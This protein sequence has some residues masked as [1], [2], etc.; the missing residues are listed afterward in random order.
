MQY[1]FFLA[2][3]LAYFSVLMMYLIAAG[4]AVT[5]FCHFPGGRSLEAS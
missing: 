2:P 5:L 3:F 4:S 1:S